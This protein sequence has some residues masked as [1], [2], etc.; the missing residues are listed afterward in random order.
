M[1][2]DEDEIF[3]AW[4]Q[5]QIPGADIRI[6]RGASNAPLVLDNGFKLGVFNIEK[7]DFQQM[8][9]AST[10]FCL[11]G[12]LVL[13]P[14][15]ILHVSL[16]YQGD[17]LT[18]LRERRDQILATL[19][20]AQNVRVY[21][22]SEGVFFRQVRKGSG[23]QSD[24][25]YIDQSDPSFGQPIPPSGAF[26]ADVQQSGRL[27]PVELA[28]IDYIGELLRPLPLVR[29]GPSRSTGGARLDPKEVTMGRVVQRISALGGV[30]PS[31][32]INR[33][34][35]ALNHLSHKHFVLL[36]GISGTGKTLLAK[37]YAYAILGEADLEFR[38]EDF[39]MVP[40][41][42]DWTDPS[43]LLGFYDVVTGTYHRTRF[44]DAAL[45]ASENRD[46]PV[47]VCLDEMN[48]AQ[49]EY[50]FSDIMSSME[51][52]ED[53]ILHDSDPDRIGV[54]QRVPWP[55]NLFIA[56]TVNVDETT[57]PF[58][59]KLLDRANV[60]DLS[61]VDLDLFMNSLADRESDLRVALGEHTRSVLRSLHDELAPHSLHF[62]YRTVEEM[63]RFLAR[64]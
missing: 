40:V 30:Y 33:Y 19:E 36:T 63:A 10:A 51:S 57:R 47:F 52:E 35:V 31:S 44:L 41:R 2:P 50:Y 16:T 43:Y 7:T 49:P 1:T 64:S 25:R 8:E 55:R 37:A 54:P 29:L 42:P 3:T 11:A 59:P 56:G 26:F 45:R 12:R 58:S 13:P 20:R 21:I 53:L 61:E 34:H 14:R 17:T 60:I 23:E 48:L 5:E 6:A 24:P 28:Y 39:F 38:S 62:G 46:R 32:L 27:D 22:H 9:E 4:L 18:L 15:K